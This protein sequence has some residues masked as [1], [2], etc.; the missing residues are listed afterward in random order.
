MTGWWQ[1]TPS[2]PHSMHS[3][4]SWVCSPELC[5]P[6]CSTGSR[7][8]QS[9]HCSGS[10]GAIS[11]GCP[12]PAHPF[13]PLRTHLCH[14]W[15]PGIS[16]GS[17]LKAATCSHYASPPP[18]RCRLHAIACTC[19]RKQCLCGAPFPPLPSPAAHCIAA[20]MDSGRPDGREHQA[21]HACRVAARHSP[22]TLPGHQHHCRLTLALKIESKR[23]RGA[24]SPLPC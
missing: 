16:R 21:P 9:Q 23:E 22:S 13:A 19:K 6:S 15:E 24:L 12:A 4:R 14:G 10:A 18:A 1:L 11:T 20:S 5:G 17:S 8:L 2:R 3:R 7:P